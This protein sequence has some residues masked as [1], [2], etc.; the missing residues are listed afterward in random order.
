M[1]SLAKFLACLALAAGLAAGQDEGL[2]CAS[3]K[4]GPMLDF[5]FRFV[6]GTWFSLPMKQF[7]GEQF[8]LQVAM[9][10]VPVNGTPGEPKLVEHKVRAR[11]PVPEG[12]RGEMYFPSAI[13]VG[14][15]Q[16]RSIWRISDRRGRSCSGTRVFKAALSR[17][18]RDVDVTLAPGEIVDTAMYMFRPQKPLER[19]HLKSPRRLKIFLSLDVLGRRGR[20]VRTRMVHVLPHIAALRQLAGSPNFNEFSV[21]TFSFE[22]QKVL[23]RQDYQKTVDF[24]AMIGVVKDLNP[25]TVDVSELLRGSEMQFFKDLLVKELLGFER[26]EAVVF[27]GQDVHFGRRIPDHLLDPFRQLGLEVSFFDASR[28]AW[29][30]AMG[31]FVRALGGKE[32]KL[33]EPAQL[34]TAVSEFEKRVL[35]SRPQ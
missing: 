9:Q 20:V 14:T 7:W 17:K 31:N 12:A 28:F 13:S 5:E 18:D 2:K 22:D 11:Q 33:R 32:F 27:L 21:V 6:A 1:R 24:A 16:Y 3:A 15:G 29:R 23:V 19:P 26:P 4:I 30:G 25:E 10:V 8:E 35:R 34:A